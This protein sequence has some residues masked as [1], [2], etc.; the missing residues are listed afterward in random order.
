[1][2]VREVTVGEKTYRL[3]LQP[4]NFSEWKVT[5]DK[6]EFS[7][8]CLPLSKQLL[9]LIVNGKSVQAR[10]ERY[11]DILRIFLNGRPYECSV[12]D[13]RHFRGRSR[14]AH[15]DDAEQKIKASM[16]GKVVRLLA[17]PGDSIAPGQG[18]VVLE[19][20]KMQNE[21]RSTKAGVVKSL[22]VREGANVNAGDLLAII[23]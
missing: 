6:H 8:S 3:E 12:R 21:V 23:E 19:A 2:I 5:V 18:I 11:R 4:A 22:A 9:S 7:V 13:P 1:M 14:A 10:V 15:A 16:P 17:K 20:M